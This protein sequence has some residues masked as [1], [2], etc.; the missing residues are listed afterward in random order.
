[1]DPNASNFATI[2]E[3]IALFPEDVQEKLKQIRAVIKAAAPQA[4]E[5][6]SYRMPAFAF[7]GILVYFAAFENHISFFPTSSGVEK[8]KDELAGYEISKGTIRF[9]LD[10]PIPFDLIERIT[11]FR[12]QENGRKTVKLTE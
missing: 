10:K 2:D 8:F 5:R 1:M 4:V 11:T 9:P 6:I 3:Y 12:V 7:N